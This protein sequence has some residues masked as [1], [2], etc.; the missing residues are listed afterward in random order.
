[1]KA[2]QSEMAVLTQIIPNTGWQW[3]YWVS[4]KEGE[5]DEPTVLAED[6]PVWGMFR[7]DV[8][9]E[10]PLVWVAGIDPDPCVSYMPLD[11]TS[12]FLGYL[13][14]GEDVEIYREAARDALRDE[15]KKRGK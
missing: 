5:G 6:F 7:L 10:S 13:A 1:M 4:P 15:R 2:K 12:C 14:P 11:E 8:D 3:V 9:G